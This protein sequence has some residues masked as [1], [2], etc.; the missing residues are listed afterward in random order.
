MPGMSS[1]VEKCY[2]CYYSQITPR[3]ARLRCFHF[4]SVAAGATENFYVEGKRTKVAVGK[5]HLLALRSL[6]ISK[7]RGQG[8]LIEIRKLREGS[9]FWK[10]MM[11]YILWI[12]L[13]IIVHL[14]QMFSRATTSVCTFDFMIRYVSEKKNS[15]E[16]IPHEQLL[17]VKFTLCNLQFIFEE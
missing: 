2:C 14:Y 6:L 7:I 13:Q 5:M 1:A 3:S 8:Q 4:I 17:K 16:L 10:M 9:T 12:L 15:K 11:S